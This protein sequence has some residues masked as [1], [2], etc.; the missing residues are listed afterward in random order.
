MLFCFSLVYLLFSFVYLSLRCFHRDSWVACWL[1]FVMVNSE[2]SV[3]YHPCSFFCFLFCFLLFSFPSIVLPWISYWMGCLGYGANNSFS[4]VVSELILRRVLSI[5]LAFL[6]SSRFLSPPL[7]SH[8]LLD[9]LFR[10]RCKQ[11]FHSCPFMVKS[12]ADVLCHILLFYCCSLL[13]SLV[14]FPAFVLTWISYW[15]SCLGYPRVLSR[16][17]LRLM[18]SVAS[19]LVHP[20]SVSGLPCPMAH[21]RSC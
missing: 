8:G 19:S 17:N 2:A 6:F 16:V 12:E 1:R 14:F 15:M 21:T 4:R 9:R 11:A 7:P 5:I 3:I 13:F 18:C 10:S 20:R